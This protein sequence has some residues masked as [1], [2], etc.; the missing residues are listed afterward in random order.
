MRL[1]P[2]SVTVNLGVFINLFLV[3]S[4]P[5]LLLNPPIA[6]A[7]QATSECPLP[8]EIA[9]TFLNSKCKEVK[10]EEPRTV[11][12]YYSSDGNKYGRYLTTKK[13]KTNIEVIKYLA[14]NQS[15]QPP[16]QA[17]MIEKVTLPAGTT[18]YEGIVAPQTPAKCYP[19]GG[20]QTFIQDSRDPNIKWSDGENL[21]VKEFSCQ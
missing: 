3:S 12:R 11:Y 5:S 4:S 17:T 8:N 19:G 1:K 6:R 15:W 21:V 20:Q 2:T 7:Q 18:V 10:L 16:N 14:L 13:Y 9:I